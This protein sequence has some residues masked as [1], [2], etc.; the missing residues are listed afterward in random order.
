MVVGLPHFGNP[1]RDIA[2]SKV[3]NVLTPG[4]QREI[5]ELVDRLAAF[6]PNHVAV[7]WENQAKLD[8][9]YADYRAGKLKLDADEDD[10]I[11]LRLAAKLGL[12]RVDAVDWNQDAPGKDEDYDFPGWLKAHGRGAEWDA[13]LKT[14]Q[15]EADADTAFQHCHPI[16]DW[17]RYYN[18]AAGTE[19]MARPYF[20]IATFGDTAQNPGAAWDGTWYARNLR[21][22]YNLL[23]AGGAPGD[24]TIA[25]FG[26][27]HG[28]LLRSDAAQSGRFAVVDVL[29]Y[30]RPA[31]RGQC[32]G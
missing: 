16:A 6:R 5:A 12:P 26:A 29:R 1:G 18:D 3:E 23:R 8:Q 21:I 19:R 27:G 30:L 15:A 32:Q 9:R 10:Q 22:Y 13:Y 31:A 14:S 4:R 7:E 11:G 17:V 25:I 20:T 2:D 28:P 24:R